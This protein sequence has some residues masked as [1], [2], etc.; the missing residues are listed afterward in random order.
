MGKLSHRK[1]NIISCF[2]GSISDLLASGHTVTGPATAVAE[3]MRGDHRSNELG[4]ICALTVFF[5]RGIAAVWVSPPPPGDR[6]SG[7]GSGSAVRVHE[8]IET[9]CGITSW[10]W[11]RRALWGSISDLLPVGRT[12][13]QCPATTVAEGMRGDDPANGLCDICVPTCALCA[14][15]LASNCRGVG[16]QPPAPP[17]P[18]PHPFL[19]TV[20]RVQGQ[21][22]CEG[23]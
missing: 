21:E 2:W 8:K 13:S 7:P 6:V 3:G 16:K 9:A 22:S 20:C 17:P 11:P 23:G 1:C 10:F 4:D 15:L 19:V 14:C 5:G 18:P 12:Q